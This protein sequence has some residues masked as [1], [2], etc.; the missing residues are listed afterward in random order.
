MSISRNE[1][2]KSDSKWLE[3]FKIE[4]RFEGEN[5]IEIPRRGKG[6]GEIVWKWEAKLGYG[7]QTNVW[8]E[9]SPKA[10]SLR[11]VK[12]IEKVVDDAG[13]ADGPLKDAAR[14]VDYRRELKA[15][16]LLCEVRVI[17]IARPLL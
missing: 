5:T 4:T 7:L 8:L 11:V 12:A 13:T 15:L 3:D 1:D 14:Q 6:S 9:K 10:G 2:S 17:L 16:A